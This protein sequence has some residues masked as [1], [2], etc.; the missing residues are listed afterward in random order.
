[1]RCNLSADCPVGE[2]CV[3]NE[4]QQSVTVEEEMG[5]CVAQAVA[6][7]LPGLTILVGFNP[8]A[9]LLAQSPSPS[10]TALPSLS[11]LPLLSP[12]PSPSPSPSQSQRA[13]VIA[14]Q[15]SSSA[16]IEVPTADVEAGEV[17]VDADGTHSSGSAE[18]EIEKEEGGVCIAM[19]HMEHFEESALVFSSSR[20]AHVLC[21]KG[22]NCATKGHF[23]LVK[24]DA[25]MM[26]DYCSMVHCVRRMMAVNS[27]RMKRGL[28]VKGRTEGV[29]FSAMAVRWGTRAEKLAVKVA[30]GLGF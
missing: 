3:A 26:G 5:I 4:E 12:S 2:A 10:E 21:D 17:E 16:G 1:M 29:E 27:P 13:P 25:M 14:V 6:T 15:A 8:K 9:D 22:G 24:G 19:H 7:G 23:I 18:A 28:R 30:L 20:M 11:P